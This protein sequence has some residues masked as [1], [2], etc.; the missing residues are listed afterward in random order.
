MILRTCRYHAGSNITCEISTRVSRRGDPRVSIRTFYPHCVG[1]AYC[2]T[3]GPELCCAVTTYGESSL[4]TCWPQVATPPILF[5]HVSPGGWVGYYSLDIHADRILRWLCGWC[6]WTWNTF[7]SCS[8]FRGGCLAVGVRSL[9]R[10]YDDRGSQSLADHVCSVAF[11]QDSCRAL[12]PWRFLDLG[13]FP[14]SRPFFVG[15]ISLTLGR[16]WEAKVVAIDMAMVLSSPWN[17]F[18]TL[19]TQSPKGSK[20]FLVS[21]GHPCKTFQ[22]RSYQYHQL[23][24]GAASC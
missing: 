4:L 18:L 24:K 12:V 22:T 20:T 3:S 21:G 9:E 16:E 15:T 1:L 13:M 14:R 23:K 8:A 11:S 5:H 17:L 6:K 19:L 10:K 2:D 7:F